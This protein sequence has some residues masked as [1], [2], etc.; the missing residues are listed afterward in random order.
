MKHI[1]SAAVLGA[2]T[3]GS[4]IAAHLANIGLQV[5]LLDIVPPDAKD[6]KDRNRF[7]RT[8][9]QRLLKAQPP[10]FYHPDFRGRIRIGN[11]ED[12]L[13]RVSEVDWIVEAVV[14]RPDIKRNLFE[15]VEQFR[16]PGTLVSTNTSGLSVNRLA[17]GRSDDFRRHFL[18]THFFN[19]P[20]FMKLLEL[21]PARDTD[22][23]VLRFFQ[24]F[25]TRRLGKG[26]V[27][28]KDTPNFIANRLGVFGILHII[29]TMV[30]MDL[31][32]EEVDAIT[33]R[34]MGRPRSATFRTLDMVG[35]DVLLHVARNVYENAPHDEMREV[36]KPPEFLE[37]MVER[38]L[39]GDKAGGGFYKKENG[40]RLVLD[41]KTLEYRERRKPK[42][43]SVEAALMEETPA[44]RIRTLLQGRD[45]AAEFAWRTLSAF[46]V[47]AANRIPEIADDILSVD[48]AIKWGFNFRLGPFETYDAIGVPEFVK[49]LEAEGRPVPA[50]VQDLLQ[51]G[52]T[53]FYIQEP[54][55]RLYF[56]FTQKAH[57]P[58]ELPE[59]VI[60]LDY[61]K[62]EGREVLANP[63]A[64]LIDLGDGVALLEFH[65]KANALGPGT[66]QMIFDSLDKV[67][68]DFDAL[69]IGNRGRHFSAGAN[70][71]LIL[72]AIAEE[73]W[74]ELD[75]MVRRF[76]QAAMALKYFEKPVVAAPFGRVLGG[77]TE[78]TMHTHRAQ[79][80]AETYM[81]LVEVAVGLLPAGGGTK[82]TLI[83]YTADIMA[84][85][86]ADPYP[87]LREALTNIGMAKVSMS[88]YEAKQLR[89]LRPGDGVTVNDDFL[90]HD[91]KQV[92]LE[93]VRTGFTP[94]V[95]RKIKVTGESGFA[96][97]K[98]LIYNL[99]EGRQITE[100]DAYIVTQIAR[101]LTGGPVPYGT[102]L[103][104]QDL[105]DL[106]REAFLRLCGTEKTQQRIIHM[107]NTGKPLRN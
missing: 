77:G 82:E 7:P 81:G 68:T 27:V 84:L 34:A 54:T 13:P 6:P 42:F 79:A 89:Y 60:V 53:S 36:F 66:I 65:T 73:E 25:G 17:E 101:V 8:A 33:G 50:R 63:E 3:M 31:T 38:G 97:L 29:H 59:G 87:F 91:A 80:A 56:D 107:L 67:R 105:L 19:P 49:R 1:R 55:R 76:Q 106:E 94:P 5:L 83:R 90:L 71:A 20:R 21:V 93:M 10:A 61:L 104:E 40:K 58:E 103:S 11:F 100:H 96:Y 35:L 99:Q 26:V 32:V 30:E 92:A 98:M 46:L 4:Q 39:L 48:N 69:V 15:R 2:G 14:E 22:P 43:A 64:S 88:A 95:P 41:W 78:I 28:A 37:K 75:F 23:E 45:K 62:A 74:E 72:Q 85:P 12:D 16:R 52:Q 47:Y 44:G 24:D 102:E 51:T 70:L 18:G 9:L 86:D 57:V